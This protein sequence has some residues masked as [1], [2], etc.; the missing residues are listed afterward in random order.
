RRTRR[1]ITADGMGSGNYALFR[2][3]ID[4]SQLV[5]GE[6]ARERNLQAQRLAQRELREHYESANRDYQAARQL[7]G[8]VERLKPLA[9]AAAVAGL[10]DIQRRLREVEEQLERLDLSAHQDLEQEQQRLR[11]HYQ[12][13]EEHQRQ[14]NEENGRL[15]ALLKELDQRI[16][17]FAD[18]SD[19]LRERQ[20]RAE[21][22]LLDAADHWP[23]LDIE[24][25]T[26]AMDERLRQ[27][28]A[29]IDF[30]T[31]EK[32]L[33]SQ[34]TREAIALERA[35]LE[36]NRQALVAD[37]LVADSPAEL[38]S[39]AFFGH[40]RNLRQ[41]L[42]GLHNRL[43]NNVLLEKQERLAALRDTFNTTFVSDLCHEIHQAINDGK[44]ILDNLNSELQHHHFGADRERF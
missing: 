8:Q 1:G 43:R 33:S 17:R 21:A 22:A 18:T 20:E 29:S 39:L 28:H 15:G 42:D 14:L 10:L 25:Y 41:Q 31:E 11:G 35:I 34:L 44:R 3:D 36:Y 30:E 9:Q 38:H 24:R 2:C 23:G 12:T 13:L 6:T 5:F 27:A 40:V 26:T 37:S 16:R 32:E 7:A 19:Q 4:D